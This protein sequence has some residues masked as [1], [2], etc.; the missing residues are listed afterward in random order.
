MSRVVV[1]EI[2]A[3]VGNDVTFNDTVKIDTLKGKT[4]AGSVTVQ[5]EGTATTNL[6]Q[7]LCKHWVDIDNKDTAVTVRDSFN[8]SSATDIGTGNYLPFA[9][10]P[11]ANVNYIILGSTIG[12]TGNQSVL[13]SHQ[14]VGVKGTGA[15]G[16]YEVGVSD[17]NNSDADND[18]CMTA[19]LGDL[20]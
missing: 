8:H 9:T 14:T 5:G 4:T 1:N 16:L 18:H 13:D 2:E 17:N 10:N 12:G 15:A 3:K 11:F 20:A 19:A 6:Q 7:A